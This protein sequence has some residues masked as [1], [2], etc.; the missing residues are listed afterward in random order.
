LEDLILMRYESD[1]RRR[2]SRFFGSAGVDVP[3]GIALD[4][5]EIIYLAEESSGLPVGSSKGE[6]ALNSLV[7]FDSSGTR[8]WVKTISKDAST[9][10]RAIAVDKLGGIYLMGWMKASLDGKTIPPDGAFNSSYFLA[11]YDS[12]GTRLWLRQ[13]GGRSNPIALAAD[14][15]GNAY[16][17]GDGPDSLDGSSGSGDLFLLKY[18]KAGSRKWTRKWGT[19]AT[20]EAQDMAMDQDGFLYLTGRADGPSKG[21]DVFNLGIMKWTPEPPSFD[22]AKAATPQEKMI[23]GNFQLARLDD[24]IATLYSAARMRAPK[25]DEIKAEQIDWLKSKRNACRTPEDLR[26]T[27]RERVE[28]LQ[29][30]T[31]SR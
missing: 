19:A 25:P 26:R 11:R 8:Q 31:G 4:A 16:L 17:F 14:A 9:G 12:G 6:T 2:W 15:L 20:Q 28:V 3:V 10:M 13:S 22:C 23:C 1:G 29:A 7:K 18:D 24:S 27:L 21:L 5:R 30:G